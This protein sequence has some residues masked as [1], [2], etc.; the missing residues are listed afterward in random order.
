MSYAN[1][2]I[3]IKNIAPLPIRHLFYGDENGETFCSFL[4]I[5][6]FSLYVEITG[7]VA[8]SE[9]SDI[10]CVTSFAEGLVLLQHTRLHNWK[11]QCSGSVSQSSFRVTF[12][13]DNAAI[14]FLCT[15]IAHS[16]MSGGLDW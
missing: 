13:G 8:E 16:E 2:E 9:L 6:W 14:L 15:P 7:N 4:Y 12:N 3:Y 10:S 1:G 11:L 5:T